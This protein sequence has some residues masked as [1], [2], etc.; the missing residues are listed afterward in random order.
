MA[1]G[2]EIAPFTRETG[3]A[4]WNRYAAVNDEFVPIHMDDEAGR[5]A[6]Y[7][8]A[9]GMGHMQWAYLHNALRGFVG[10]DGAIVALSCQF[11][12]AN[13]KGMTVTAKG[14]VTTVDE[15]AG[16]ATLDVW[17]EDQDGNKLAPGTAVVRLP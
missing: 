2:D 9:F 15:A 3:F 4:N 14:V 12:G 1:V 7:P 11:R 17:T 10:D 6:G 16:T 13:T 5:A 8:T